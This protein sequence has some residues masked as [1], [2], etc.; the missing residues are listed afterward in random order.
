[1]SGTLLTGKD[2]GAKPTP[3]ETGALGEMNSLW[4]SFSTSSTHF[5]KFGTPLS[6]PVP[7]HSQTPAP[8]PLTFKISTWLAYFDPVVSRVRGLRGQVKGEVRRLPFSPG[9]TLYR[10]ATLQIDFDVE[11]GRKDTCSTGPPLSGN[12][13]APPGSSLGVWSAR[14]ATESHREL[15]KKIWGGRRTAFGQH[16]LSLL[17]NISHLHQKSQTKEVEN[18]RK[19]DF[20][21]KMGCGYG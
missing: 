2:K 13:C 7:Y 12:P 5:F 17:L 9:S 15:G 19:E 8:L 1:M 11:R 21:G 4:L 10:T 18:K 3:G 16:C 20:M 6:S 14:G